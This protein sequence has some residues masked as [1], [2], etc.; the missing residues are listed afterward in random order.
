[1]SSRHIVKDVL[2]KITQELK[3]S[4]PRASR[5]A[6]LLLMYHLNVDELWLLMNQDKEVKEIEKLLEWAQ[7]RAKNEPLEY[8]VGSVSFYSEE[9]YID[10][11][12]LIPRPETEL[13]IDEVLKNIEDKNSPLNIVEV[14]VGSGIISIILAK[15]LPN[16]KFIAVDI[17][18]AALGVARKNIEKFSLEDRIELRHGSLLEP[19]KEKIDYL[20][21]NPPYIADDV[22]LESN[23]SY[24]PQNAL[25]GGSVGDEIIKELLDGVLKAEINLF[26]CEMGYDQKDKIQ[27][28]LN[29][30]PLKSL[31]FYKDYSDFDRGF[32][33]RL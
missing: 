22:S 15:S 9:F 30:K 28:Y 31:V 6:Q 25:F 20:V 3:E 12:A 26:S 24:E 23:L 33:L 14:G 21:S 13:L 11:G 16:A 19:I 10:S 5:E 7:R 4:I 32:T 27:N 8:I 18:Q 2:H 1:M 17:S 29:N